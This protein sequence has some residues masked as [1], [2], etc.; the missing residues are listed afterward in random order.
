M[1]RDTDQYDLF[2]SYSTKDNENGWIKAFLE[3]LNDQQKQFTGGAGFTCF[4]DKHE[5]R[6]GDDW[7]HRLH[8]AL[9]ASRVFV[10]FLSPNSGASIV[11][12]DQYW[13]DKRRHLIDRH[14]NAASR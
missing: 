2:A 3:A 14:E 6:T 9:A 12:D 10:A 5:I 1:A 11:A 8:H 4:F 13:E 7:R